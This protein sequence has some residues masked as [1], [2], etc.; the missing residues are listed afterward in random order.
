MQTSAASFSKMVMDRVEDGE[1]L[2]TIL[3]LTN[4]LEIDVAT[5][6]S[7]LTS[8]LKALVEKEAKSKK[9][10]KKGVDST[11]PT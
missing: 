6:N 7:F 4:E 11:K 8:E 9:L 10:M 3:Q 5:I 2:S 1:Y